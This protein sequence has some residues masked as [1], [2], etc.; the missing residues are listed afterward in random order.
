PEVEV[1]PSF[2]ERT[3]VEFIQVI[4]PQEIRMRVWERGAGETLACGTGACASVVA[5][6]LN[7]KTERSVV[8]H[9]NGGDL[10]IQWPEDGPAMMTGPAVEVFTGEISPETIADWTSGE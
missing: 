2:P 10:E 9:L 6:I 3:N 1:H 7:G 8:V 5:S 4:S